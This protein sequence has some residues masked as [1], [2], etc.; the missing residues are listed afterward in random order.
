MY[1]DAIRAAT[2]GLV[3]NLALGLAKGLGGWIAGSYALVADAINSAGDVLTSVFVIAALHV[4]QRPAD[5]AHPYGY[6]RAEA[7]AGSNV[8]LLIVVS[9]LWIGVKT[10]WQL[11]EPGEVPPLWSL[12]IA[13]TNVLLKEGLYQYKVR[14]ARRSGSAVLM[15]NAWDHR[16]DALSALAVLIGLGIVRWGGRDLVIADQ[17]A[18]LVVVLLILFAC[19]ALLRHAFAELLDAQADEETLGEIARAA[20]EVAGVREI[21]THTLRVRKSGMELLVDIHVQVDPGLSI[22]D[23]HEIGHRVKD[24]L[25]ARYP[26][27]RDVLVHVEPWPDGGWTP[28]G[29]QP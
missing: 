11:G 18:A 27:V 3:A 5:Q 13:G 1:R 12:W 2:I 24:H 7:V 4:A 26:R 29:P 14:V 8:A 25:C 28:R 22:G 10:L 15:A 19:G 16:S 21:E 20:S 6:S 23:A 9:A 17:I